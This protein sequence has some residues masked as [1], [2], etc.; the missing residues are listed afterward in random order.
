[1]ILRTLLALALFATIVPHARE[2]T[3]AGTCSNDFVYQELREAKFG[4]LDRVADLPKEVLAEFQTAIA[5]H[6]P[7]LLA[8]PGEPYQATDVVA[9]GGPGL[10]R[11]LV[12]AGFSK[13]LFY[14]Y[15]E[16]G[17]IAHTHHVFVYCH[18]EGRKRML[19]VI[20]A[21]AVRSPRDLAVGLR[22]DQVVSPPRE[23]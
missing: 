8:E 17:G 10:A 11:R 12:F 3:A 6:D 14:V 1:M 20:G 18:H 22:R 2:S 13:S 4:R 7:P 9:P 21:P 15:Y 23:N 16:R 5:Q 19:A